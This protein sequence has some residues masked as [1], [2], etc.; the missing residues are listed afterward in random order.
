MV[1]GLYQADAPVIDAVGVP[2]DQEAFDVANDFFGRTSRCGGNMNFTDA[3]IA[4]KD[5]RAANSW[6]GEECL[7][8]CSCIWQGYGAVRDGLRHESLQSL[9]KQDAIQI[10]LR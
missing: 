1:R 8:K 2:N 3:V 7:L 6:N 4:K 9:G 10:V 5:P